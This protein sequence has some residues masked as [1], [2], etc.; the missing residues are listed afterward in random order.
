MAALLL[1][2][3][4][5][6]AGCKDQPAAPDTS[7]PAIGLSATRLTFTASLG[8]A[9]P[10]AQDVQVWNAGVGTLA[11]TISDD[12][13]WLEV[14]PNSGSSTGAS[15]KKSHA[16]KV[17]LA[18]LAAGTHAAT[19]TVTSAGASNSPQ[20]VA[21][22]LTMSE[23][24]S[25]IEVSPES[26]SFAAAAGGED[27]AAQ[28]FQVWNSGGGKLGYTISSDS[29]WLAAA[30]TGG[31]STGEK[32]THAASASAAGLQPGQYTAAL[33]VSDPQAANSPVRIAVSFDIAPA[34]VPRI[35]TSAE[36]LSFSGT[37]GGENPPRQT[38][39]V[40]NSGS[41][42]L[43]YGISADAVWLV[44]SPAQGT[45][46]GEKQ[47]HEIAVDSGGLA[48][49]TYSAALTVTDPNA[50][51]SP[52]A[53][54]VALVLA[55]AVSPKICAT[56]S[57]LA[58]SGTAGGG[59]PPPQ[60]IEVWNCGDGGE[61]NYT[62]SDDAAWLAVVPASGTSTGEKVKHLVIVTPEGLAAG[63]YA[64]VIRITDPNALSSPFSIPVT[65]TLL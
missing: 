40:W 6:P 35:R 26:L 19:V 31:D 65:L 11:Y 56:P 59:A 1:V 20:T 49:G 50:S 60:E 30:P 51:N 38:L 36:S 32:R 62:I 53:I 61:I 5:G 48:E 45:S 15:E 10:A 25:R 18:G 43:T 54:A 17:A 33:T 64:A 7:K 23:K 22:T 21:V 8:E 42:R 16:V 4:L 9:D 12:A 34:A 29:A 55:K 2:L 41:G 27:P 44:A 46:E 57:S 52:F 39:Q 13:S 37:A 47:D 14:A 63:V 24:A 58:F 3:S 28:D